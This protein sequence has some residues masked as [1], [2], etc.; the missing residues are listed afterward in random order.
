MWKTFNGKPEAEKKVKN[1]STRSANSVLNVYLYSIT[2]YN[3]LH[4]KG[5]LSLDWINRFV[6]GERASDRVTEPESNNNPQLQ[7]WHNVWVWF[8]NP[9]PKGKQVMRYVA[10]QATRTST[11]TATTTTNINTIAALIPTNSTCIRLCVYNVTRLACVCLCTTCLFFISTYNTFFLIA[12]KFTMLCQC[13]SYQ[14]Q[15]HHLYGLQAI[16][17]AY[18]VTALEIYTRK[19]VVRKIKFVAVARYA[20]VV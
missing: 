20:S 5:I 19:N 12:Q 7:V 11:T 10:L 15:N 13:Q 3:T 2:L 4:A 1:L 6:G 14:K 17:S 18:N 9:L 8:I 16:K